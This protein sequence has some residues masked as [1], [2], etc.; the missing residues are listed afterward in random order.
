MASLSA[1]AG[2]TASHV[3]RCRR[4]LVLVWPGVFRM[5][6]CFAL[7]AMLLFAHAAIAADPPKK[8]VASD[9]LKAPKKQASSSPI[10]DRFS[11]RVLYWP[12]SVST[13]LRLDRRVAGLI[14][15]GTE[16]IAEDD[17]GMPDTKNEGRAEM[18]IRLRERNR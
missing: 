7:S 17:L 11:L 4:L 14:V 5:R 16:L 9:T 8:P 18:M 3:R 13:D 12:A 1:D 10:T 6:L 2:V 15:P